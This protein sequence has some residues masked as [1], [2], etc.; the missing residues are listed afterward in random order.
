MMG[1]QTLCLFGPLTRAG[2]RVG[3]AKHYKVLS[4]DEFCAFRP[5]G[6]TGAPQGEVCCHCTLV[7]HSLR[8]FELRPKIK[9]NLN[10][11]LNGKF[12]RHRATATLAQWHFKFVLSILWRRCAVE[13][14]FHSVSWTFKYPL[15]CMF[16][17]RVLYLL[18]ICYTATGIMS[19]RNR[20][21]LI[22]QMIC[23]VC[24]FRRRRLPRS[25]C[26]CLAGCSCDSQL[27]L[28]AS[29]SNFSIPVIS[30]D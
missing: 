7:C 8:I 22:L 19:R 26:E 2:S 30:S 23:R 12:W 13:I 25:K 4:A 11:M 14:V 29:V 10:C 3:S 28:L 16:F 18:K 24:S 1:R 21:M 20:F 27:I 17:V 5:L 15:L 9:S 6:T